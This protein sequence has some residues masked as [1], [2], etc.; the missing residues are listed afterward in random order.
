MVGNDSNQHMTYLHVKNLIN[1]YVSGNKTI[2]DLGAGNG[3][4]LKLLEADNSFRLKANT[5]VPEISGIE[6]EEWDLNQE[7]PSNYIQEYDILTSLDVIEHLLNPFQFLENCKELMNDKSL[8]IISTPNI[9]SLKSRIRFLISGRFTGF[10]GHNFN[11]G[12]PI[13]DQHLWPANKHLMQ[14]FCK[15]LNLNIENISYVGK[16]TEL[17]SDTVVYTIKK[18]G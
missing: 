12:H 13:Y 5:H 16:K 7:I 9:H 10:F 4:F 14:Y 8:L 1:K 18:H 17:L 3:T 15:L 11:D 2:Y 6:C